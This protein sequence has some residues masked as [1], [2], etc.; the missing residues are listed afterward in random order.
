MRAKSFRQN[1]D[2]LT[3]LTQQAGLLVHYAMALPHKIP[4]NA[5]IISTNRSSYN[6]IEPFQNESF[7][8][9]THDTNWGTWNFISS[10]TNALADW[11]FDWSLDRRNQKRF[12][13][14]L[15]PSAGLV[16]IFWILFN[17][18]CSNQ[19]V[20]VSHCGEDGNSETI[21]SESDYNVV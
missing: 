21:L 6:K 9:N 19:I 17:K 12:C 10:D 16:T 13:T 8:S 4:L 20:A 18:V 11:P 15:N 3:I 2:W 14:L 7:P 5:V 1:A